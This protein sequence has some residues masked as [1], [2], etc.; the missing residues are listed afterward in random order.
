MIELATAP[1]VRAVA[2]RFD[3][4]FTGSLTSFLVSLFL[5]AEKDTLE[6]ASQMTNRH[7]AWARGVSGGSWPRR[8]HQ[9]A[10]AKHVSAIGTLAFDH[11]GRT[12]LQHVLLGG[13]AEKVVRLALPVLT[14]KHRGASD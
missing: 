8:A 11:Y 4:L 2:N 6:T 3:E 13:V 7:P 12:G 9:Q 10:G 1:D 14:V 5:A